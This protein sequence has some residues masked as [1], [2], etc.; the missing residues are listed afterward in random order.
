MRLYF[1]LLL[2]CILSISCGKGKNS[3]G[4]VEQRTLHLDSDFDGVNDDSELIQRT[5]PFIANIP[6]I[7]LKR[8][9]IKFY[10][11]F[12]ELDSEIKH[13]SWLDY[14]RNF[15]A[16]EIKYKNLNGVSYPLRRTS[17]L[18]NSF[19]LGC[20]SSR[21]NTEQLSNVDMRMKFEIKNNSPFKHT[22]I[23]G[24]TANRQRI[25]ESGPTQLEI[26]NIR[27]IDKCYRIED[28]DFEYTF[29]TKRFRYYERN[30]KL[31]EHLS[32]VTIHSKDKSYEFYI[33]PGKLK[34]S[35]LLKEVKL[36]TSNIKSYKIFSEGNHSHNQ[37]L[38][39]RNYSFAFLSKEEILKSDKKVTYLSGA[40]KAKKINLLGARVGDDVS[41]KFKTAIDFQVP[42]S[43]KKFTSGWYF[44]KRGNA[45]PKK[46]P[47]A[48]I[49]EKSFVYSENDLENI[50][51]KLSLKAILSGSNRKLQVVREGN[52]FII[53]F[54]IKSMNEKNVHLEAI[55]Q[56]SLY[57]E[58]IEKWSNRGKKPGTSSGRLYVCNIALYDQYPRYKK[59]LLKVDGELIISYDLMRTRY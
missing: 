9:E 53:K 29:L 1:L 31:R 49:Y 48:C 6:N 7:A 20:L 30:N 40:S 24:V 22:V 33:T 44:Y 39:N 54:K 56:K 3:S 11:S 50:R 58:Q 21:Y 43:L 8:L 46:R 41:I 47:D 32:Y 2:L 57:V 38:T 37:A 28:L 26:T 25:Q 52:N 34:L 35:D 55:T 5:N 45:K 14:H 18:T 23:S 4:G 59:Q 27:L 15:I 10:E 17:N 36:P 51:A 16:R 13:T 12:K 19:K 42:P